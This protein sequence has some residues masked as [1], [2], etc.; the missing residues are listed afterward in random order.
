MHRATTDLEIGR[1]SGSPS[2][3]GRCVREAPARKLSCCTYS[4]I[5]MLRCKDGQQHMHL[6]LLRWQERPFLLNSL[7][8]RALL[9]LAHE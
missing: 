9:P 1:T 4:E 6:S 3:I 8:N 2:L 5:V 7:P